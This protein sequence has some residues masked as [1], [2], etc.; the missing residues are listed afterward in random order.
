M[1]VRLLSPPELRFPIFS[2]PGGNYT[3]TSTPIVFLQL[4]NSPCV[5]WDASFCMSGTNYYCSKNVFYVLPPCT[6]FF[7]S[8]RVCITTCTTFSLEHV[9]CTTTLYYLF[10][11]P[12]IFFFPT[13]L[14]Q[15][16]IDKPMWPIYVPLTSRTSNHTAHYFIYYPAGSCITI[17]IRNQVT[18][19]FVLCKS[20]LDVQGSVL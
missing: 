1:T 9:Y 8:L 5:I 15:H 2:A 10:P 18:S 3:I 4:P 20:R 17:K 19:G 6:T 16:Q 14:G 7:L 11:T 13:P 12:F